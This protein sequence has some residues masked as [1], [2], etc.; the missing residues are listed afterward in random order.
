MDRPLP[1]PQNAAV[2]GQQAVAAELAGDEH[3]ARC[4][5]AGAVALA[6]EGVEVLAESG[7]ADLSG[8]AGA[9]F[10]GQVVHVVPARAVPAGT[11]MTR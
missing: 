6:A 4:E 2:A 8:H 7:P 9:Q 3:G 10:G 1:A 11:M 5:Y